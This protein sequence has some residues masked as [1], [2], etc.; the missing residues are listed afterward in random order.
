MKKG[1]VIFRLFIP[2][3]KNASEPVHPAMGSFDHPAPSFLAC[4]PFYLLGFFTPGANMGRKPKFDQNITHFL[5]I[6]AFVQAHSL[7]LFQG[8]LGS[9]DYNIFKGLAGQFHIVAVCAGP[10]QTNRHSVP[11][12]QN[13]PF[14]PTFSPVGRIWPDFFPAQRRFGHRSVQA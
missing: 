13:A 5:K 10:S 7:R 8:W 12:R 11:L 6:I 14:D 1:D 3:N 2:A 4:V 9:L